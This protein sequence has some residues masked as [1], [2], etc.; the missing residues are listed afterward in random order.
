MTINGRKIPLAF[1]T[2]NRL[3]HTKA[4]L[5]ALENCVGQEAFDFYFFSDAPRREADIESV[6]AVRRL[7]HSFSRNFQAEIIEQSS[8][9]GLARSIVG[10]VD[11]LCASYGWV[12]VLED[13]LIVAPGFL[14]FMAAAL[15]H[16]EHEQAVMQVAATTLAP[17]GNL[18]RDAFLLPVTST[19]G[20][21]TWQRSW[22]SFSWKPQNWPDTIADKDWYT[23][24]NAGSNNIYARMLEDRLNGRNDSWGILWWYA[25]SRARGKVV[26][27]RKSLVWNAGFD[28]SG[29]HCGKEAACNYADPLTIW[30]ETWIDRKPLFPPQNS[31]RTSDYK[32]LQ[33]YLAEPR[34]VQ[35]DLVTRFKLVLSK[36][37]LKIKHALASGAT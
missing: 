28:G 35:L 8:N 4:A 14:R 32:L 33:A 19:W 3:N 36:F 18:S 21:A 17:P 24:F 29:V 34:S 26:Y 13:D 30:D 7:L 15:M 31:I 23:L 12:V 2:Y 27:P 20:W 25:V 6:M 10:G 11:Q 22:K 9:Q 37:W 5:S 1:F 16:Y